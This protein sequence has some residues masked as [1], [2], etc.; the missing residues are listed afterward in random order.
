MPIGKFEPE[1]WVHVGVTVPSISSVAV[2]ENETGCE[3]SIF[4]PTAILFGIEIV[5][6]VLSTG[7]TILSISIKNELVPTF[8][9]ISETLH[10]TV[11][12]PIENKEFGGGS[13]NT[14]PLIPM[15]S[16]AVGIEYPIF[17]ES[18]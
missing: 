15:L 9:E 18:R 1:L 7:G 8:P 12:V 14:E 16:I 4:V 11:V 10:V 3:F 13:H 17:V 6:G 2:T 5:G